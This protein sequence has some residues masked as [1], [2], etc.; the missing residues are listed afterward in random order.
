MKK[1]KQKMKKEKRFPVFALIGMVLLSCISCKGAND[2]SQV[3]SYTPTPEF[4]EEFDEKG[5]TD[6][7]IANSVNENDYCG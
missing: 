3:V 6:E 5:I 4:W 1:K 2:K 7:M